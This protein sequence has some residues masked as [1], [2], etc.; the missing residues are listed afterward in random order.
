[1]SDPL[2]IAASVAGLAALTGTI[3]KTVFQFLS[4]IKDAPEAAQQLA[5]S[6]ATL[7]IALG[8]IQQ[9]LLDP[10]FVSETCDQHVEALQQCLIDCTFV[11]SQLQRKVEG[12]GLVLDSRST[13]RSTW[14]SVKWSFT[15]DALDDL[16][17][18]V[19]AEKTT[20]QLLSTAFTGF[21]STSNPLLQSTLT[22]HE[23]QGQRRPSTIC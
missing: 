12:C 18:R 15:D 3:S 5:R 22:C 23:Q 20:L 7:N 14:Q 4:S 13:L 11:F 10:D 6:L 17:K 9:N 16:L 1:M 2:S 19:E 8:Q 21:V